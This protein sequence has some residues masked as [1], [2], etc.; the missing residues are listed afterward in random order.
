MFIFLIGLVVLGGVT[1][2]S[3]M[4]TATVLILLILVKDLLQK[5]TRWQDIKPIGIEWAFIGYFVVAVISLFFNGKPP[6]PWW[7]YLSKFNWILNLY[8]LIYAFDQIDFDY[9]KWLTYFGFAFLIPNIY[10]IITYF[11]HYDYAT[12]K[13]IERGTIG[14]VNSST[15]HAHGNSLIFIFFA[16]LYT[17]LFNS[18]S[19]SQKIGA[20][21]SL[22]LMGLSIFVSFTRGIWVALFVSLFVLFLVR[23]KKYAMY[24]VI[25]TL[26]S[27][28]VAMNFSEM[29]RL[30]VMNTFAGSSDHLRAELLQ[31]HLLMFKHHPWF[32][33]GFWDSYRQ[34]ADYWPLLGLP[35]N[36]YESHAHNQIVN[37]LATTGIAGAFFFLSMV[38]FFSKQTWIFIKNSKPLGSI[39]FLGISIALLLLQFFLACLTD[40]TFEYAKIRGLLVVGLAALISFKNRNYTKSASISNQ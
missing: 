27:L 32:G 19:K 3:L 11:M 29:V 12:A 1:S 17:F 28:F 5:K 38:Y 31:V 26:L 37:V 23:N 22:L 30:R 35:S 10:A 40:V 13:V 2:Q 34:I 24:F 9:K 18:L 8:L 6:V 16:A 36:H 25:T 33:I 7:T 4:D 21:L 39:Y 15:Y 20:A 14:L